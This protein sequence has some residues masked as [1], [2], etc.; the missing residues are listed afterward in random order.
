MRETVAEAHRLAAA[1]AVARRARM[2]RRAGQARRTW[3]VPIPRPRV[4]GAPAWADRW[5]E[6]AS[7]YHRSAA[8]LP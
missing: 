3:P 5:D 7:A 2:A 1:R 4:A 8:R 6:A